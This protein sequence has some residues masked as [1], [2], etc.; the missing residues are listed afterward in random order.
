MYLTSRKK[1]NLGKAKV[2]NILEIPKADRPNWSIEDINKELENNAQG[3][4]GYVVRWIDQEWVV[5]SAGYKQCWF[6]GR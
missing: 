4:L 3:I 5:Q 2:E 6:N 1:L